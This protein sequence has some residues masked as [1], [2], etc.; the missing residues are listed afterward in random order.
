MAL[1]V[2]GLTLAE[3]VPFAQRLTHR[4]F[5]DVRAVAYPQTNGADDERAGLEALARSEAA[6]DAAT[7]LRVAGAL[8]VRADTRGLVDGEWDIDWQ[9]RGLKRPSLS[10]RRLQATLARGGL[11]IDVGKQFIRWGRTDILNP[12]DRFAPRD[13][14]EVTDSE[15]L[16]VTAAR[17]SYERGPHTIDAVWVPRFTPSRAPLPGSR[18]AVLP[19]ASAGLVIVDEGARLP[20]GSQYGVRW[21]RVASAY[22]L[23]LCFY[24]G[25]NHLPL[26]DARVT[27]PPVVG[28]TRVHPAQI[29]VGAD[30]AVPL[31]WLTLKG[32]AAYFRG[33]EN[34][35]EP[36]S[37]DYVLYVLQLERLVGEWSLAGGYAGER[38]IT[39]RS[40]LD[41]APDRGLTRALVG[42]A[43]YTIDTNRSAAM[44]LAVRQNGDGAWLKV[45]YS[46]AI[47]QHWR[48]TVTASLIRG[49]PDDFLGQ[50]RRNS[51]ATVA[52]RYSF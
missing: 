19:P 38:V 39:N 49:E 52:L 45:E 44:E 33:D 30:L 5:L 48:T 47:G 27:A 16:G 36:R 35:A 12:T 25:F 21:N 41:F 22:E 2:A 42:R 24:D 17:I 40:T 3:S 23:S 26:V 9:D 20:R 4:G 15:F 11:A 1:V 51:H 50:Y 28:L 14:L 13:Y 32:E 31:P 6:W 46:H 29:M 8:D 7:W 34:G 37:D 43:G 10:V 18:W